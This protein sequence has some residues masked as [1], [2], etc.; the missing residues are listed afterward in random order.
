MKKI[1]EESIAPKL[2]S[3]VEIALADDDVSGWLQEKSAKIGEYVVDFK[4]LK[5][6]MNI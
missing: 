6:L 2:W 3:P 4:L 5:N 1:Y